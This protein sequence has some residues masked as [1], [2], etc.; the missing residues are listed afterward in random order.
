M[1]VE[2][3][4]E[5]SIV[6]INIF[7]NGIGRSASSK[8]TG[9]ESTRQGLRLTSQMIASLNEMETYRHISQEITDLYDEAGNPA[10]T[11]VVIT[12]ETQK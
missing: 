6:T 1:T 4:R 10:G 12:I 2:L 3:V 5:K 8:K 9:E 11:L 7:D